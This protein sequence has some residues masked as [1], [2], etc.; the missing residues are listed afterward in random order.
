MGRPGAR[1]REVGGGHWDRY[2]ELGRGEGG[3]VGPLVVE[4]GPGVSG[5]GP[6]VEERTERLAVAALRFHGL[7]RRREVAAA[8]ERMRGVVIGLQDGGFAGF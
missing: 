4:A 1:R 8:E 7:P 5:F 3:L 6:L 2:R